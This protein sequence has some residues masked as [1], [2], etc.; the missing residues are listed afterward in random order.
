M[1]A[2][3]EAE[4]FLPRP[5]IAITVVDRATVRSIVHAE[6]ALI[7]RA[8]ELGIDLDVAHSGYSSYIEGVMK[9]LSEEDKQEFQKL[10]VEESLKNEEYDEAVAR[11]A[12]AERHYGEVLEQSKPPST[13]RIFMA[14]VNV[15]VLVVVGL[16]FAFR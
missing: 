7:D 13:L 9:P 15:T 11:A 12:A 5:Q 14:G 10:F 2:A 3:L 4:G 8:H 1:L 16:Y 6:R